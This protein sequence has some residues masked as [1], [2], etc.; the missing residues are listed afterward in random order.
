MDLFTLLTVGL[1]TG[2]LA[3]LFF[4]GS[5]YGLARDIAIGG[6]GALLGN[7]IVGALGAPLLH[8]S[9]G[10]GFAAFSGAAVLLVLLR[11]FHSAR[12]TRDLWTRNPASTSPW[13]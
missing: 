12:R 4:G 1:V 2:L 8:G 3:N 7:W 10:T 11:G 9:G 5:G 13:R 6:A